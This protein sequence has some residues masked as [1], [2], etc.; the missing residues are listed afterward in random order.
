M[1]CGDFKYFDP[2]VHFLYIFKMGQNV[3]CL[4]DMYC[5]ENFKFC[6]HF[7]LVTGQLDLWMKWILNSH[8]ELQWALN[9]LCFT[10]MGKGD[11]SYKFLTW[12]ANVMA[13]NCICTA[14]EFFCSYYF[15]TANEFFCSYFFLTGT[16]CHWDVLASSQKLFIGKPE[17]IFEVSC[18]NC[19]GFFV[20]PFLFWL[21]WYL[22]LI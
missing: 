9:I 16:L 4:S 20:Y 7:W 18:I 12:Y 13:T 5:N 17:E 21:H 19:L 10:L 6:C 1:G 15:C 14:I 11:N 22:W 3:L 8:Y 2:N